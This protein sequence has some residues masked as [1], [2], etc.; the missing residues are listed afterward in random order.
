M[1]EY[2]TIAMED[3][4]R[5]IMRPSL[6][7]AHGAGGSRHIVYPMPGNH[8]AAV[9]LREGPVAEITHNLALDFLKRHGTALSSQFLLAPEKTCELYAIV[10]LTLERYRSGPNPIE[11][12]ANSVA[13]AITSMLPGRGAAP[14]HGRPSA[15][16]PNPQRTKAFLNAHHER[17]FKAAY[18]NIATYIRMGGAGTTPT[19]DLQRVKSRW[20]ATHRSLTEVVGVA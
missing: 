6:P 14:S 8:S 5:F 1:N 18:A 11:A 15:R 17:V 2:V 20:E 19:R 3:E 12:A 7:A 10:R 16:V 4:T 13:S 9:M